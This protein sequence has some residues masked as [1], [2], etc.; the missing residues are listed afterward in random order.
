[1]V[2]H[3]GNRTLGL[4]AALIHEII[5]RQHEDVTARTMADA[6]VDRLRQRSMAKRE[7]ALELMRRGPRDEAESYWRAHL[8]Q[9]RDLVLAVYSGSMTIDVLAEQ[10]GRLRPV[11]KVRRAARPSTKTA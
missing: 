2:A 3:C 11:G 1:M 8:V 9:T 6:R 10:S 5:R 4:F 7:H